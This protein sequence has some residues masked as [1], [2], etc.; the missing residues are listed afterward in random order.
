M[1]FSISQKCVC[2]CVCGEG[3]K[4]QITREV[5]EREVQMH[6]SFV[7][8]SKASAVLLGMFQALG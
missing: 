7:T 3:Q 5:A 1:S 8:A 6:S 2:V 4:L